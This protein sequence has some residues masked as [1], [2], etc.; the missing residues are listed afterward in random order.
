MPL[1]TR[2]AKARAKAATLVGKDKAEALWRA[3]HALDEGATSAFATLLA[4]AT[5]DMMEKRA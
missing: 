4:G 5:R 1:D 2:E 3:I